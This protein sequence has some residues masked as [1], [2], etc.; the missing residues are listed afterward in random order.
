MGNKDTSHLKFLQL[1]TLAPTSGSTTLAQAGDIFTGYLDPNF[2][3]WGTSVAGVDTEVASVDIFEINQNGTYADLFGSFR[4]DRRSL[5]LTQG[6]IVEFCRTNPDLLRQD[7][8]ATLFLFEVDDKLFVVF[9]CVVDG[10]LEA[11]VNHFDHDDVWRAIF[12]HR[13]VVSQR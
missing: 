2:N 1:A 11:Y 8:Y 3:N 12:R 13:L 7:G 5:C 4:V 9:V 6:Q 10:Q